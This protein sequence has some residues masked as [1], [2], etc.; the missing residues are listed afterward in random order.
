MIKSGFK[1]GPSK[2]SYERAAGFGLIL[3]LMSLLKTRTK[4][5]PATNA[6]ITLLCSLWTL[7]SC[8]SSLRI[9]LNTDIK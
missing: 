4:E 2:A 8:A 3:F 1:V 7:I 9:I 6:A 5:V